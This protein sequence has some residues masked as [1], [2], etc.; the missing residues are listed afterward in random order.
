MMKPP[1]SKNAAIQMGEGARPPHPI[2]RAFSFFQSLSI[3]F[4]V[5]KVLRLRLSELQDN[6]I[7]M[8]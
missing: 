5:E 1:K 3:V 4:P 2:S 8:R 7:F 6:S